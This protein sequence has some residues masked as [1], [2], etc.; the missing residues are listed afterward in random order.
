MTLDQDI[1]LF[2]RVPLFAGL[3]AEPLKLIAFSA[4]RLELAPGHTLFRAGT[5]ALSGFVVQEGRVELTT[6]DGE[7]RQSLGVYGP[8]SLLGEMALFVET[9]R[10]ATATAIEQSAVIEIDRNLMKRMLAEYPDV[11]VH[12]Y[13]QLRAHLAETVGELAAIHE[14]LGRTA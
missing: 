14:A 6:P 2:S 3:A 9:R 1:G 8:G 4:I 7:G 10:P 5:K 13:A 12:L 11:A